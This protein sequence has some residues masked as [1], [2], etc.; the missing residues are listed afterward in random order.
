VVSELEATVCEALKACQGLIEPTARRLYMDAGNLHKY[1]QAHPAC[2]QAIVDAK[3]AMGDFTESKIFSLINKEHFPSIEYYLSTQCPDRGYVRPKGS[4]PNGLG[5]TTNV[6]ITQVTVNAI[7]SGK[8]FEAE[9]KTGDLKL[10][11]GEVAEL[12]KKKGDD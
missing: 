8:W 11:E 7:D 12:P 9:E 4:G 5:G 10:I 3:R 2:Q 1:V 6:S